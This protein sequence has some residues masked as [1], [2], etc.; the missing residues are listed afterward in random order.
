MTYDEIESNL[1]SHADAILELDM[2]LR[3]VEA[4]LAEPKLAEAPLPI[5]LNWETM[6]GLPCDLAEAVEQCKLA[7]IRHRADL[8]HEVSAEKMASI[9]RALA[10]FTERNDPKRANIVSSGSGKIQG[11]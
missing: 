2:R 6:C 8:W 7:I 4:K 5:V 10:E 1:G 9:F 3:A 11:G